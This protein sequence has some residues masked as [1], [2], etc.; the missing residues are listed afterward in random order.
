MRMP[1]DMSPGTM[2]TSNKGLTFKVITYSD[3]LKIK[4]K[5][6]ETGYTT[7]EAADTIRRGNV[8]DRL[9]ITKSG[10]G[11]I[12]IGK[13]V[14][15][16]E[17]SNTR[18]YQRWTDMLAKCY[19]RQPKGGKTVC[20]EWLNFQNFATWFELSKRIGSRNRLRMLKGNVYSP[21]NCEL[22]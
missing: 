21:E 1:S 15:S 18:E 10:V 9:S 4:V 17:G 16:Q 6:T 12:G 22:V 14:A 5:F 8:K 20:K 3:S 19:I 11:Y 2:H 7:I 13:Y